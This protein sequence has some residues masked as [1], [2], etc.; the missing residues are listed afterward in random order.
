MP[1][2]LKRRCDNPFPQRQEAWND[3]QLDPSLWVLGKQVAEFDDLDRL[4]CRARLEARHGS[5]TRT[6]DVW[7]WRISTTD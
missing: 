3:S 6:Y 5:E 4:D 7:E 1:L 2:K